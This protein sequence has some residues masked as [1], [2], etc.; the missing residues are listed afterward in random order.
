VINSHTGALPHRSLSWILWC[1]R[2]LGYKLCTPSNIN[3]CICVRSIHTNLVWLID[4]CLTPL[5]TIFQ[6]YRGGQFYWWRKPEY[7]EK[8][9]DQPQVT[10][11][12]Y[13]IMLDTS[14][15]AGLELT[16]SVVIGTDCIDS[17]T[18]NYH[19]ITAM[20]SVWIRTFVLY[21]LNTISDYLKLS[22]PLR[23]HIIYH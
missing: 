16:T 2:F 17:C 21:I 1:H 3:F 5:S 9:N 8:T 7:R 4:W 19:T 20:A 23:S 14:P 12:R 22:I 13:H 18:S 11:N 10:D 6:L 15:W